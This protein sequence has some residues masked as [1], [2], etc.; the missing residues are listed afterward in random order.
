M[1]ARALSV[2]GALKRSPALLCSR[3]LNHACH[4]TV[5]VE[6]FQRGANL[7]ASHAGGD[8][9][10]HRPI[11]AGV[12]DGFQKL[13]CL[14]GGER[15][16]LPALD[17]GEPFP[18]GIGRSTDN[19]LLLDGAAERGFQDAVVLA[20]ALWRQ[21]AGLAVPPPFRCPLRICRLD[22]RRRDLRDWQRSQLG[23]QEAIDDLAISL[24]R[25]WAHFLANGAKPCRQPLPHRHAARIDVLV[26]IER[27]QQAAQFFLG[28]P[29]LALH[30]GGGDAPLASGGVA[31]EAVTQLP[32]SRR[33]LAEM[34][35]CA[36]GHVS[37]LILS[38]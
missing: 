31:A 17:L 24:V 20:P 10:Q 32:S 16:H 9:N 13:R 7:P 18:E 38:C 21:A 11:D 37:L 22:M 36:H 26:Q 5:Q 34:S 1:I 4:A 2:L 23:H 15:N 29:T 30:R 25:L 3:T 14:L 27:S 28:V 19:H 6:F 35:G 12:F 8:R 33:A